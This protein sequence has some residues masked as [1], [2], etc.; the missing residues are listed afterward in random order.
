MEKITL[1]L[2]SNFVGTFLNDFFDLP[3]IKKKDMKYSVYNH[4]IEL[5]INCNSAM[6]AIFARK[7]INYTYLNISQQ[8]MECPYFG[9]F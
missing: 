3:T 5:R 6:K 4:D 1:Q 7:N 8:K 9:T 2:I